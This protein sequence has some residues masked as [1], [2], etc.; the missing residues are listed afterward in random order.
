MI[1]A[2]SFSGPVDFDGDGPE[3][4]PT[5]TGVSDVF[6]AVH[7]MDGAR[8]W[9]KTMGGPGAEWPVAVAADAEGGVT[10]LGQFNGT[11]DFD[12]GEETAVLTARRYGDMFLARLDGQ[13]AL[14]WVRSVGSPDG[15]G[16]PLGMDLLETGSG[17]I[18]VAGSFTGAVDFDPGREPQVSYAGPTGHE[19]CFVASYS[20]QGELQWHRVFAG[21][22]ET[23]A[24]A[25]AV[26]ADGTIFV[27]GFFSISADLDPGEGIDDHTSAGDAD[28][29]VIALSPSG[30]YLGG[31]AFGGSG[32]D[33]ASSLAVAGDGSL[34]VGGSFSGRSDL[35]PG[36]GID[37]HTSAGALDAYVL[38]L[39]RDVVVGGRPE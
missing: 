29:F 5:T 4:A 32:R 12:P 11:A 34:L 14:S 13:G 28:A 16:R 21:P 23:A 9:A 8:R 17:S 10:L 26:G 15:S 19:R 27:A 33:E 6:V 3:Q 20:R 25:L 1:F 22:Y 30:D 39:P 36:P 31:R 24:R 38:R 35:D 2:G 37:E 7:D 18:L